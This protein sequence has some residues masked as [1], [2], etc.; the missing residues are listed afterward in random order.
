MPW[1]MPKNNFFH[2]YMNG[3]EP[4]L[5]FPCFVYFKEKL[6]IELCTFSLS[7]RI[8]KLRRRKVPENSFARFFFPPQKKVLE[9]S[10]KSSRMTK[11]NL[12]TMTTISR[13]KIKRSF[14]RPF[15]IYSVW[16]SGCGN[17][18]QN[19]FFQVYRYKIETILFCFLFFSSDF[20]L[21]F[22]GG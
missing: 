5:Y 22:K 10:W 16:K 18:S 7:S 6:K 11:F 12:H 3:K 1:K 21:V 4:N 17:S 14:Q 20:F 2:T 15:A 19:N 8:C 9:L 13:N